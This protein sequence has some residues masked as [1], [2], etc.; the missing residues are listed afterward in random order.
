[1]KVPRKPQTR[2]RR[3]PA[4]AHGTTARKPTPGWKAR[5]LLPA[6]INPRPPSV[7]TTMD[8]RIDEYFAAAAL[9]GMLAS[10]ADEPDVAFAC[11][12]SWKMGVEM[13]RRAAKLRRRRA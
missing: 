12:W 1:M 4:G 7:P 3:V 8:L 5:V 13:A 11:E 2:R 10:Q 6:F 9:M